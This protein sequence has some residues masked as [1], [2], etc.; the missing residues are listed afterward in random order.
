[1]SHLDNRYPDQQQ[2]RSLW[3]Y[4]HFPCLQLNTLYQHLDSRPTVIVDEKT[5]RIVQCN[6]SAKQQGIDIDMG[7]ASAASLAANVCVYPYQQNIEQQ[8]L[9]ELADSLYLLSADIC[10]HSTNGLLLNV[11]RM[12]TLYQNL[13]HYWQALSTHLD[14]A[15]V[16]YYYATAYSVNG[17]ILLAKNQCNII[18]ADQHEIEQELHPLALA[19]TGLSAKNINHLK[20]IGI[21]QVEQLIALPLTDIA[22]RFDIDL[23]NYVGRFT[24]QLHHPITFYQP[25]E[26]FFKH[27]DLWHDISNVMYLEKPL[28]SIYQSLEQFLYLRQQ[29][30][31]QLQVTLYFRDHHPPHQTLMINSAH[32][33]YRSSQ[34]LELSLLTLESVTLMAPVVAISVKACEVDKS[35]FKHSDLFASQQAATGAAQLIAKL[36]AKLGQDAV[37]SV[38]AVSDHR[39]EC[40]LRYH[41]PEDIENKLN[42]TRVEEVAGQSHRPSLLLEQPFALT[43][44][45]TLHHGPE[46]I[47][48][49]WWDEHSICRDYFIARS[50]HGQW[51]WVFRTPDND[52][53]IHGLFS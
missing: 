20:R 10:M 6:T 26:K 24:G 5:H 3:L 32:G 40:G 51:L 4:L 22:K 14:S 39:P 48:S 27:L 33:E 17:A 50:A 1:M 41:Q 28:Y 37:F 7:L 11:S 45:V 25:D 19:H 38:S 21:E 15:N 42:S 49:G 43:D 13:T 9:Q 23:V 12:L 44:N 46:R 36:Q 52:W 47:I 31:Q 34:W 2:G 16:D 29:R 35:E 18:S 53:F 8:R 30:C